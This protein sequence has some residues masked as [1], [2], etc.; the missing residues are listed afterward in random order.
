[1]INRISI[2]FG[3]AALLAFAQKDQPHKLRAWFADGT[4]VEFEQEATGSTVL[5]LH[6]G[7]VSVSDGG[8][9]RVVSD[10][11]GNI[12]YAYFVD[13]WANPQAEAAVTIRIKPLDKDS[14]TRPS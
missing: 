9:Q 10:K 5:A 13:A 12:L 4:G 11:D 2:L 7:G 8:I 6:G 3:A 14:E 1:M